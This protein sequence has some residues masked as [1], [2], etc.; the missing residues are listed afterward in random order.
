MLTHKLLKILH[1]FFACL[2]AYW[3]QYQLCLYNNVQFKEL[4]RSRV[5]S[6]ASSTEELGGD[7]SPEQFKRSVCM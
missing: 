2:T 4:T 7:K 3:R 1:N 6:M 5:R